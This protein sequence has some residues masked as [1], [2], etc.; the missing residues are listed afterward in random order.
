[1]AIIRQMPKLLLRGSIANIT[2]ANLTETDRNHLD[3]LLEYV[4]YH[5]ELIKTKSKVIK[6][7]GVTIRADYSDDRYI[8]EEEFNIAIWR[9]LVS[10][11][12]HRDYEF[13]CKHCKSTTYIT[14]RGKPKPF[15]RIQTPC[16]NCRMAEIVNPGCS[17]LEPGTIANHDEMQQKYKNVIKGT[18][19]FKSCMM[20]IDGN[21]KYK[22][23]QEI[24]DCPK[25]LKRFFS[26]FVW[27]YFRQ[28][29]K[30]NKR[31]EF[32]KPQ[33][34]TGPADQMIVEEIISMCSRLNIDYNYY[35]K[36]QPMNG[37]YYIQLNGLLTSP[38]FSMELALIRAI[39]NKHEVK[40]VYTPN[41]INV[42]VNFSAPTIIVNV[43]RPEHIT[44]ADNHTT[45]SDDEKQHI[46]QTSYKTVGEI[47]M[48]EDHV[49]MTEMNEAVL[50]VRKSLPDGDCKNVYDIYRQD[51]EIYAQF[52]CKYGDSD[53]KINHI[54]EFLNITPR[55]VKQHRATIK[56]HCLANDFTLEKVYA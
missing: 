6:E 53:P 54:A 10:L 45:F 38:E 46:D 56:I 39:A 12:Y 15:D 27:N 9:G 3:E 22:N 4:S 31:K 16:P 30:E 42:N 18:P 2:M 41:S 23:P 26:E 21:K 5:S 7:F 35:A 11:F 40:I 17:N 34:I 29:I 52:S 24:I 36:V 25:Q 19:V 43:I 1:M 49:V 32:K 50:L 8:A 48:Q 14:K 37:V 28:Q 44:M 47:R 33:K 20:C 13:Q 51:G 55:A